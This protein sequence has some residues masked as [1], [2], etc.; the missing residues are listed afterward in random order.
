MPPREKV[1]AAIPRVA[2]MKAGLRASPRMVARSGV[3]FSVSN[4]PR[5][6]SF[7]KSTESAST[8]PGAAAM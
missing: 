4:W 3:S 7:K 6:G 2:V 8:K 1:I 5:A